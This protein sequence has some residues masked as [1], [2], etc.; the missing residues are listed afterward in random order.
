MELSVV[1]LPKPDGG[2][3]P[4]GLLPGLARLWGKIRRRHMREWEDNH[5]RA[6]FAAG[7]DA[8]AEEAAW[9]HAA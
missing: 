4:I 1:F 8:T 3:R 2:A 5:Q 6:L 7:R 9:R